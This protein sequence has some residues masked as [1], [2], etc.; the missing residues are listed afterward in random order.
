MNFIIVSIIISG[1]SYTLAK[2]YK[3]LLYKYKRVD[4]KI[5][6]WVIVLLSTFIPLIQFNFSPFKNAE[7]LIE[8]IGKNLNPLPVPIR[9]IDTKDLAVSISNIN[10]NF[11]ELVNSFWFIGI[12]IYFLYYLMVILK[13]IK[14]VNNSKLSLNYSCKY[15]YN[16]YIS[17]ETTSPF[18]CWIGKHA[19]F[20]PAKLHKK[21]DSREIDAI[22]KHEITHIRR[23]DIFKNYLFIINKIVFWFNPFAHFIS[24]NVVN[25]LETACDMEVIK[26]SS[27][28]ER[29]IY[30]MTL[31]KI[32]LIN[33]KK[34][35]FI[36][37]FGSPTKFLKK[38]IAFI[39]RN[40][41]ISVSN[42]VRIL[43]LSSTLLILI[44]IKPLMAYENISNSSYSDVNLKSLN[45]KNVN[46]QKYFSG[47]EGSIVV[48]N[49]KRDK[50]FIYNQNLALERTSP[51]STYKL[52]SSIF[53]LNNKTI[54]I[55]QNKLLWNGKKTPFKVWNRNQNLDTALRYSV[56][57]YF[58]TLDNYTDKKDLSHYLSELN[59]GNSNIESSLNRPYWLESNLK[60]SPLEQTM[61]LKRFYINDSLFKTKYTDLVKNSLYT[62]KNNY[63]MWGKTGTAIINK[64]EIKGWYVGGFEQDQEP[65]VF[66]TL[67]KKNDEA[68]GEIAKKISEK[69]IKTNHFY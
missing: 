10:Y 60:I 56:N 36:L 4:Y 65:Y 52:I 19:I 37:N 51:D 16:I 42:K 59:Y 18:T 44:T 27:K 61:I 58:E 30:G 48:Y 38:R 54:S 63:K 45:Y 69:I 31:L 66:A 7:L 21:L 13:L 34:E 46:L 1:L 39:S 26:S 23:K 17:Q 3:L 22:I 40:D 14:I 53:H 12:F 50:F 20:I 29:K 8:P 68:N 9:K 5:F 67:I 33:S 11:Q 2:L 6:P 41:Y 43:F 57:W 47:Y 32:S 49:I 15:D 28:A 55:N 35:H 24:K 25:D 64:H 62:S